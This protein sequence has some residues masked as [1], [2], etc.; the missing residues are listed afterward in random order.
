MKP[1]PLMNTPHASLWLP[2]FTKSFTTSQNEKLPH[3][4]R[5]N[6]E[7]LK[8]HQIRLFGTSLLKL[9]GYSGISNK[10]HEI[11]D[12]SS[13]ANHPIPHRA[14]RCQ[15]SL[16]AMNVEFISDNSH[17][18]FS[19]FPKARDAHWKHLVVLTPN[20][21][22]RPHFW[23]WSFKAESEHLK[24]R[25]KNMKISLWIAVE[26]DFKKESYSSLKLIDFPVAIK[27]E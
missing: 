16:S 14:L 2:G 11:R 15:V 10:P 17:G 7:W 6:P 27:P 18:N 5:R 20:A 22:D 24:Y 19:A 9:H 21:E 26:D 13:R 3:A 12:H 1:Y 25:L 23:S 8:C 4:P